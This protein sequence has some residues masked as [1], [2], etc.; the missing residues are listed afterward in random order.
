MYS[1]PFFV[2]LL[3]SLV[4]AQALE[5]ALHSDAPTTRWRGIETI[6]GTVKERPSVAGRSEI[7]LALSAQPKL[8]II[9][10]RHVCTKRRDPVRPGGTTSQSEVVPHQTEKKHTH[11]PPGAHLQ[12]PEGEACTSGPGGCGVSTTRSIPDTE[13][14]K[15]TSLDTSSAPDCPCWSFW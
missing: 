14:D 8:H 7:A 9:H 13:V 6:R 5:Y 12:P 3:S 15:W 11:R 2:S 1:L 10:R 4:F